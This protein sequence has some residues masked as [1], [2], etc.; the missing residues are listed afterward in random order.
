MQGETDTW[1]RDIIPAM[2]TN[3]FPDRFEGTGL[4]QNPIYVL[5]VAFTF[6]LM[7]IGATWLWRRR[8]WGYVISGMM[9]VM[10]TIETAGIAID[11]VFGHLHDESA[12]LGAVPIMLAL[13][14]AGLTFSTLFL[15]GIEAGESWSRWRSATPTLSRSRPS[16]GTRLSPR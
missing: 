4:T 9:V 3:T 8:G 10:L 15:R 12:P 6:P 13:T 14:A 1:L 16:T 11:Q 7:G 5:D 2:I